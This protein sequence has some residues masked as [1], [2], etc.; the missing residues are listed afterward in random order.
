MELQLLPTIAGRFISSGLGKHQSRKIDTWELI[1]VLKSSLEMF[2]GDDN[3]HIPAGHY[4][5]LQP[6]IRHGGRSKY[7]AGLSFFW[8]HFRPKN[9][10]SEKA[11][12]DFPPCGLVMDSGRLS[13]YFQFFLSVRQENPE[14]LQ[15]LEIIMKLI[16]HETT[17]KSARKQ[18]P[19]L[20]TIPELARKADQMIKL[21]YA[22]I[23]TSSQIARELRVT[24]SYL[25]RLYRH[26]FGCSITSAINL[27]RIYKS[28]NLL[29]ETH[30]SIKEIAQQIGFSDQAYFRRC[31]FHVFANTPKRFRQLHQPG[32]INVD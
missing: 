25:G 22:E 14:D 6:G 17:K 8:I 28:A 7:P 5:L 3:Y 9:R 15:A 13:E 18:Q 27:A 26:H 10:Q 16:L 19:L 30:L 29:R 31:F 11:L 21:H 32:H 2:C 4:L 23:L 20:E 24:S 12:M 1:F